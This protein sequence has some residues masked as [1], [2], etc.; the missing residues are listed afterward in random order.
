MVKIR[1]IPQGEELSMD[2]RWNWSWPSSTRRRTSLVHVKKMW[3]HG[4]FRDWIQLDRELSTL[5][6]EQS[7]RDRREEKRTLLLL[8]SAANLDL[9]YP[10][11]HVM[12]SFHRFL[13]INQ[14]KPWRCWRGTWTERNFKEE[15]GNESQEVE[16]WIFTLYHLSYLPNYT[17][18]EFGMFPNLF[19][20]WSF[21]CALLI[22]DES[23]SST[24]SL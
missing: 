24:S 19:L 5:E 22:D 7:E 14:E 15:A 20:F 12:F 13:T 16:R 4:D 21:L 1:R 2:R 23:V 9:F 6:G 18:R 10:H 3:P 17:A 8:A 11:F